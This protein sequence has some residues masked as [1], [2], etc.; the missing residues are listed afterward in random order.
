[1]ANFFI[2]DIY[3]SV[4]PII[5]KSIYANH[6]QMQSTIALF[7]LTSCI[8]SLIAGT[9]SDKYGRRLVLLTSL[10]M[11]LIGS[12]TL[13]ISTNFS[14]FSTGIIFQGI[15][16]VGGMMLA[17]S[18][19]KDIFPNESQL[20]RKYALFSLIVAIAPA[21]SPMCGS[22]LTLH[23]GW[24]SMFIA[25]IALYITLIS[26]CIFSFKE[27]AKELHNV[28]IIKLA[29]KSY[30]QVIK[31]YR[32]ITLNI[33]SAIIFGGYIC[34]L[35]ISPYVLHIQLRLT[36][37]QVSYVLF[38]LV[39][40][41]LGSRFCNTILSKHLEIKTIISFGLG[42]ILLSGLLYWL[43]VILS[44]NLIF[45]ILGGIIYVF[46]FGLLA[47]NIT[48]LALSEAKKHTGVASSIYGTIQV[49]GGALLSFLV[50]LTTQK[51]QFLIFSICISIIIILSISLYFLYEKYK[52]Q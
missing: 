16:S 4:M 7:F 29:T 3:L 38:M 44:L 27:T 15:G 10:T 22:F 23:F 37:T 32:F 35:T 19:I 33:I 42:F 9:T 17:R 43:A 14:L 47:S 31:N 49:A 51:I 39:I 12:I 20:R 41:S 30:L 36:E 21:V 13:S 45:I 5:E 28:S 24:R 11:S 50:S 52:L 8:A 6:H 48:T 1:M 40:G 26:I 18:I 46:G 2:S 25:Q 34:F